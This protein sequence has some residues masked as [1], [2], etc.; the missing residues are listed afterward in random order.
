M[1]I[2]RHVMLRRVPFSRRPPPVQGEAPVELPFDI[3]CPRKELKVL[4]DAL[5]RA[6]ACVRWVDIAVHYETVR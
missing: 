3:R 1:D 2:S 6:G 4:Y 5:G